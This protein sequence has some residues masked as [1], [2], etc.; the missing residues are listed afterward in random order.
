MPRYGTLYFAQGSR[1]INDLRVWNPSIRERLFL[2]GS[3]PL[4]RYARNARD[5]E[6]IKGRLTGCGKAIEHVH[7]LRV[8]QNIVAGFSPRSLSFREPPGSAG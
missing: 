8:P 5:R 7:E 3:L 4:L 2:S 1:F 6:G